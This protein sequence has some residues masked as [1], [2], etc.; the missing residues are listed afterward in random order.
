MKFSRALKEFA[1][2][3]IFSEVERSNPVPALTC[4]HISGKMAFEGWVV[5]ME[6]LPCSSNVLFGNLAGH[7]TLHHEL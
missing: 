2:G 7:A 3:E 5:G 6:A 4:P 1:E